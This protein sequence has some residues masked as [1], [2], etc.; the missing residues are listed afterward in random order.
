MRIVSKEEL[1]LILLE[2]A[3]NMYTAAIEGY[4]AGV[5]KATGHP[6]DPELEGDIAWPK[7]VYNTCTKS[8]GVHYDQLVGVYCQ[9]IKDDGKAEIMI[10]DLAIETNVPDFY[11]IHHNVPMVGLEPISGESDG[12]IHFANASC[13]EDVVR[14]GSA[15]KRDH[16]SLVKNGEPLKQYRWR[17][18]GEGYLAQLSTGQK[19]ADWEHNVVLSLDIPFEQTE[20]TFL[21]GIRIRNSAAL[22]LTGILRDQLDALNAVVDGPKYAPMLV[23]GFSI[24]LYESLDGEVWY[25]VDP[26]PRPVGP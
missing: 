7:V 1:R 11:M 3:P 8:D 16:L 17:Y 9:L 24:L 19:P 25:P 14:L 4:K 18:L 2:N 23:T 5:E 20:S 13:A 10:V 22:R 26:Q 6:F 21:A 15:P 12:Y